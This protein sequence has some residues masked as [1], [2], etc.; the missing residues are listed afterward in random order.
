MKKG[1]KKIKLFLGLLCGILL[2]SLFVFG[3]SVFLIQKEREGVFISYNRL[4]S[5]IAYND[6]Y[7]AYWEQDKIIIETHDG[8]KVSSFSPDKKGLSPD[9]IV[10][11]AEGYYLLEWDYMETG[12]LYDTDAM[13]MQLDYQSN[14]K[15]QIKRKKVANLTCKNG[16]LFVGEWILDEQGLPNYLDGFYANYYIEEKQFGE[17]FHKL[18]LNE[19]DTVSVAGTTLYYHS[20][21]YY[22]TEPELDG[23]LGMVSRVIQTKDWTKCIEETE[24]ERERMNLYMIFETL[25][26]S[27]GDTCKIMEYQKGSYIFGICNFFNNAGEQEDRLVLDNNESAVFYRINCSDNTIDVI[28]E[29]SGISAIFCAEDFILYYEDGNLIRENI[30]TGTKKELLALSE[31]E[32]IITIEFQSEIFQVAYEFEHF[33]FYWNQENCDFFE[34][35]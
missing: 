32:D 17:D 9:Q 31:S 23:Y 28:S 34:K 21:G 27:V 24:N 26:C 6:N 15:K 14:V 29:R 12:E 13:I 25:D 16:T 8:T 1:S 22:C 7:V 5:Q 33:N 30:D 20:K 10:L 19:K 11:G 35:S 18:E 2:F 4:P 3:V